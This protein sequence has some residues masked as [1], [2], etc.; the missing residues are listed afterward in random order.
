MMAPNGVRIFVW[1][2]CLDI[3][4]TLKNLHRKKIIE[5]FLCPICLSQQKSIGHVLWSCEAIRDVWSQWC[6]KV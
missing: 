4:P 5:E 1:R 6:K 2:A 3:L